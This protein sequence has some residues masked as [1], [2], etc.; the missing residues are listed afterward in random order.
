MTQDPRLALDEPT[1]GW[2]TPQE[3][4]DAMLSTLSDDDADA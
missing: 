2:P 3:W 4:R 1:D